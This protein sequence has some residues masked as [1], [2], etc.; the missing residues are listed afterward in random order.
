MGDEHYDKAASDI[1][2]EI[3][4]LPHNIFKRRDNLNLFTDVKLNLEEAL[5]GFEKQIIHLDGHEV[6][7]KKRGVTKPGLR[8]KIKNEGMP[9]HEYSSHF[10][11]LFVT[12][13]VEIPKSFTE[14]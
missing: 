8:Q 13:K 10:G 3:R 12:Y 2:F 5:L 14:E 11:D 4:E 7:L 1:I 6:F 9:E